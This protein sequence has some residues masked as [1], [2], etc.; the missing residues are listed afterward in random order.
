MLALLCFLG[1]DGKDR[2]TYRKP[3]EGGG[4]TLRYLESVFGL[5]K[6]GDAFQCFRGRD[7]DRL[8]TAERGELRQAGFSRDWS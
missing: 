4:W 1:G 8:F 5:E 3:G 6:P 7:K 2:V